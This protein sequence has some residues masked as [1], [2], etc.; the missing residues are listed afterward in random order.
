MRCSSLFVFLLL[1]PVSITRSSF[2][3]TIAGAVA[4]IL[5]VRLRQYCWCGFG[6]IAGAVSAIL[7]VRE[8]PKAFAN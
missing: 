8:T 4:A 1:G 6:N 7:L 2:G 3:K 5:L